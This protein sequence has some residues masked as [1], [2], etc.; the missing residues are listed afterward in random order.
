MFEEGS[1]I[2]FNPF[3]FEDGTFKPKYFLVLKGLEDKLVLASLPTS[4]DHIPS[5]KP[6]IHGC[7]DDSTINFNCYYFKA[8]K[9]VAH[10][11]E[12]DKEFSFPKDTYVYGFRIALFNLNKFKSQLD[13]NVTVVTIKGKL[14]PSEFESLCNCL[15]HSTSVKRKLRALL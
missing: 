13:N 6:K 5:N 12:E 10:N 4:Q 1:I 8:G 14:Y 11:D 2:Y 9:N 15:K 7:I 3:Y